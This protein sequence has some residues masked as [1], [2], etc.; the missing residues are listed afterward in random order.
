MSQE[1]VKNISM[2]E[3]VGDSV[4]KHNYN[5]LSIDSQ[6]CNLSS[7]FF[8]ISLNYL[9][10]FTDLENNINNFNGFSDIFFDATRLN[11]SSTATY[12][13]SS[14]WNRNEFTLTFPVNLYEIAPF[15]QPKAYI[16]VNTANS[17]LN[18]SGLNL[19]NSK[20]PATEFLPNTIANVVFLLYSNNGTIS[21]QRTQSFTITNRI[22]NLTNRKDD[23]HTAQIKVRRY[24]VTPTLTWQNITAPF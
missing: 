14:Y 19:L 5:T 16:D 1:L 10:Y 17:A 24:R 15:R 12:V 9:K 18:Q 7:Q 11:K 20:Y 6:V 4:S 2:D 23:V 21:T 8:N 13:L 3:C 22:F